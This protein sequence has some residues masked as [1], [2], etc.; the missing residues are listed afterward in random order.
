MGNCV[1]NSSN[2][3]D[4]VSESYLSTIV[5]YSVYLTFF[6]SFLA[7]FGSCMIIL[8]FILWKDVRSSMARIVLLFLAIADLG[9]GLGYFTSS[10]GYLFIYNS[11]NN[12]TVDYNSTDILRYYCKGVSFVTT[13][14]PVS[15]FFWTGFLAVYFVVALVLR[16]PRWSKKLIIM[17][18]MIA[19]GVPLIICTV[20]SAL[21]IL[22]SSESRTTGGWCFVSQYLN[23]HQMIRYPVYLGFE[24][25]C[26]KG[27]ELVFYVTV[28]VCYSV[29]IV[30]NKR[31]FPYKVCDMTS[32]CLYTCV[33]MCNEY[34]HW[35]G[36]V[37]SI[38]QYYFLYRKVLS[39]RMHI[40][41][42]LMIHKRKM[43]S[44]E[45]W[46]MYEYPQLLPIVYL[47]KQYSI[48]LYLKLT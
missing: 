39:C 22:G 38:C 48:K 24:A 12:H 7:I 34:N 13:F 18:N 15:S 17:F 11:N 14:F 35:G 31:W 37:L 47:N 30:V 19:W 4:C 6:S 20:A 5:Y 1:S 44:R 26:G 21:G 3:S 32:D 46:T 25:I 9:S 41:L 42:Y 16:K 10:V 8:T 36:T 23:N 43:M 27:W 28:L 29:I 33:K 45:S 40:H 2:S